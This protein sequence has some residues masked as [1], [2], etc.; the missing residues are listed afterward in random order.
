[1]GRNL[2]EDGEERKE[3]SMT[4]QYSPEERFKVEASPFATD[5]E[6]IF[7]QR[8]KMRIMSAQVR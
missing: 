5:D 4:R 7:V 8:E 2:S 6:H 1:M 3:K